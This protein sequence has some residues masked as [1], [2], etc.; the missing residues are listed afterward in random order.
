MSALSAKALLFEVPIDPQITIIKESIKKLDVRLK[1][2]SNIFYPFTIMV[3]R[4]KKFNPKHLK[5]LV[6]KIHDF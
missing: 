2:I 6:V 3:V 1:M 5:L 4:S